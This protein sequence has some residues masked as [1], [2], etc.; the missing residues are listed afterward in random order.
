VIRVADDGLGIDRAKV[1]R[2]ARA[3]GLVDAAKT[4]LT[5][6]ELIRF[7]SRPGFSTAEKVTDISGRGVGIDAVQN[8]V[9]ALGGTVDIRSAP[10]AGTSVVVRL[11]TTLAIVR[12][13]LAR[14]ADEVY[15]VPLAH[16]CETV[17]LQGASLRSV[18][19][20]EVVTLRED[21]LPVLRLRGLVGLPAPERRTQQ[22]VVLELSDRRAGLVVDELVGQQEIVVK[23]FDA[24]R[25]GLAL[26]SG[27]T[28][29]GDGAPALIVD[30]S[31]LV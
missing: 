5:D 9:R 21:V 25:D 18:R 13:L 29:L 7:I 19:G 28:I 8:R 12:A 3:D 24:V 1:L 4:E 17:E 16:V 14:V 10:G 2:R 11:P 26:F 22:V 30:V 20:R 15:A 27:A 23:Q 6:E 31:S